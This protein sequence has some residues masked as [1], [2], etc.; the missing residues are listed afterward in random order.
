MTTATDVIRLEDT[1]CAAAEALA[2]MYDELHPP[3]YRAVCEALSAIHTALPEPERRTLEQQ[4]LRALA[5][6]SDDLGDY[7]QDVDMVVAALMP[8]RPGPRRH[9]LWTRITEAVVE[10]RRL[11][12]EPGYV[13]SWLRDAPPGTSVEATRRDL[14]G[15]YDADL[16]VA[17]A[18]AVAR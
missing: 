3:T 4:A 5:A 15:Q 8:F 6:A 16:T 1:W 11:R 9:L 14:I 18:E 17:L 7:R 12:E 10:L 2:H 13:D